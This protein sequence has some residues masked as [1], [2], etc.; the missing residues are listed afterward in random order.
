MKVHFLPASPKHGQPDE[1]LP[2]SVA[3]ALIAAGFAEACPVPRRGTNEYLQM[4]KEQTAH[5]TPNPAD[6]NTTVQG[7]E[8]GVQDKG[9]SMFSQVMVVK[10][11]GAE[12]F[13]YDAPPVDAPLTIVQR[14]RDLTLTTADEASA[15]AVAAAKKQAEENKEADNK[16]VWA[17]IFPKKV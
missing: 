7:E 17:S 10:R 15:I 9:T 1:H 12:T 16:G 2:P 4:R 5:L 13:Y 8:W 11:V 6:V 14:F 3:Q